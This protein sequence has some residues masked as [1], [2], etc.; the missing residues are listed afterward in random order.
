MDRG[1]ALS[2]GYKCSG[3]L[4]ENIGEQLD[5]GS[6]RVDHGAQSDQR[7]QHGVLQDRNLSK[8]S[9]VQKGT[10]HERTLSMQQYVLAGEAELLYTEKVSGQRLI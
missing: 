5:A 2:R 1:I 4:E 7:L 8:S 9:K 3:L 10:G 6:V